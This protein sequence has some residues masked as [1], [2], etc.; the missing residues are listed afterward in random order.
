MPLP[1]AHATPS[2]ELMQALGRLV[3]GL[4][5]LFWGL[6]LAIVVSVQTL[7]ASWFDNYGAFGFLGPVAVQGLLLFGLSEMG[8]FQVQERVWINALERARIL[9]VVNLGLAPFLYWQH[10]LP[11]VALYAQMVMILAVS[12][13]FFLYALNGVL[14]RLAAMLPDETLRSETTIFTA[15]NCTLLASIPFLIGAYLTLV[16]FRTLPRAAHYLFVGLHY[17]GEWIVFAL[18]LVP[19]AMTMSLLW[20]I[21]EAIL[22]SVFGGSSPSFRA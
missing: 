4:S 17:A 7:Q 22:G 16:Q 8:H 13:L 14:R 15:L 21:K 18:V 1:L 10:R 3:R 5:A 6:P 20:R 19:V 2:P 11:E 9:A 12:G